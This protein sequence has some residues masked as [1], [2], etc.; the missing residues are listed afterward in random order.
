MKLTKRAKFPYLKYF[1]FQSDYVGEK[2]HTNQTSHYKKV[3]TTA[4]KTLQQV[5]TAAQK[6]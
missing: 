5:F 3:L 2:T 6:K 4:V 1:F